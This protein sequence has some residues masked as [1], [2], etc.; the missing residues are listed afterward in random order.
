MLGRMDILEASRL[1]CKI[2]R[3]LFLDV[4]RMIV[5]H[6]ADDYLGRVVLIEPLE[7]RDELHATM[8][9]FHVGKDVARVQIDSGQ[10]RQCR[11]KAYQ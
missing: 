9:V 10:N 3:S 2:G 8:T 5:Q 11:S 1:S 7:Q 4:C 6:H